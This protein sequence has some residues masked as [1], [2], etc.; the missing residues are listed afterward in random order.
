MIA[1]SL[2]TLIACDAFD[3]ARDT[4]DGL[5][6]PVVAEGLVLGVEAPQ[7]DGL[8]QLLGGSS[9]QPGTTVSLF[10]A[11]AQEVGELEQAPIRGAEVV[12]QAGG[13]PVP[14]PEVGE[15]TY[16]LTPESGVAYVPEATW[17]LEVSRTEGDEV[18]RSIATL[19]LPPDHDF[20][21]Q[22]PT[23]IQPL[24]PITID[25]TGLGY[26]SAL[27]VVL[28]QDG[29]AYSNEPTTIREFYE[30]T[31]GNGELGTFEIPAETFPADQLFL[32]GVAGL[33]HTR[34]AD[35]DGMNTALSTVM[36]GKMRF[37]AVQTF[38]LPMP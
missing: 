36:M 18:Q 23:Q 12:L 30:F 13:E 19:A 6:N 21:D 20:A 10:L 4:V 17:T 38:M 7:G 32:V 28:D 8:D 29:V 26:D 1:F 22:I 3:R 9:F 37:Y 33:T 25:F 16:A 14:V 35:L 34:A 24:T 11:D 5:L 2:L 31:H 27:V 15:G